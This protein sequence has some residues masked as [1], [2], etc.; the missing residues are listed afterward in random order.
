M[1]PHRVVPASHD[2]GWAINARQ[3]VQH[4]GASQSAEAKA[5]AHRI[6]G[7]VTPEI[8]LVGRALAKMRRLG[9]SQRRRQRGAHALARREGGTFVEYRGATW[10][11]AGRWIA[12]N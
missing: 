3:H 4:I 6:I 2:H 8:G 1:R 9:Q 5:E 11:D 10:I 7:E 12:Q